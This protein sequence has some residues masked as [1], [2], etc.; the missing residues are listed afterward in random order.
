[1][2][3][4]TD[5]W[6]HRATART[7]VLG[8]VLLAVVGCLAPKEGRKA[9]GEVIDQ[10]AIE[11]SN[12][13]GSAYDLVRTLRPAWLRVRGRATLGYPRVYVDGLRR[14]GRPVDV[15]GAISVRLVQR[16]QYLSTQE[17]TARFG[18]GHEHGA[19]LVQTQ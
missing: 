15:L 1:M 4:T 18:T 13:S 16:V 19:I 17:A 14:S 5:G 12:V 6:T 8:A 2:F 10:E 7:A 3:M 11:A 9:S